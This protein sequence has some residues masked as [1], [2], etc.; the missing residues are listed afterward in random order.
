MTRTDVRAQSDDDAGATR[1]H[2]NAGESVAATLAGY[3]RRGVESGAVAGV[4]GGVSLLGGL[5]ALRRGEFGRALGRL[6]LGGLLVAVARRQRRP[7][8]C[9]QDEGQD[10]GRRA[11]D[12]TRIAES[13]RAGTG[14][15]G[16]AGEVG[17]DTDVTDAVAGDAGAASESD[18]SEPVAPEASRPEANVTERLGAAAFD[19]HSDEV[20]VP[21][22]AFDVGILA[23]ES[24]VFWGVRDADDA[25]LVSALY[26][27]FQERD[28][29]R[30]VASSEVDE[31]RTLRVPDAV[32][33][34]WDDVAGGGTAV[35]GGDEMAF[36]TTD[37]LRAD[38]QLLVVPRRWTD[39]VLGAGE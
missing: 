16:D 26:D 10:A 35:V 8:G 15:S 20:P 24:E 31:E 23:L 3:V 29:L 7:G 34:H 30:Y 11:S 22:H 32:M 17:E 27:P 25:V 13:D 6:A 19:E 38:D 37:D 18:E 4:G 9:R 1:G 39:D 28:G 36:A 33:N 2:R 14:R 5:R 12:R 21:Q